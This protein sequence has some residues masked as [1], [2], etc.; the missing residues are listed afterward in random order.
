MPFCSNCGAQAK[1]GYKFCNNCGTPLQSSAPQQQYVAPPPPK[2]PTYQ[3]QPTPQG[4][5]VI[6][7]LE[8]VRSRC[9]KAGSS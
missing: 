3:P 6:G 2:Q 8:R 1:E 9:S 7:I 5:R 4:E